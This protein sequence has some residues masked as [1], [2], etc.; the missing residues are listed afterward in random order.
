MK[1]NF[2]VLAQR[3]NTNSVKYDEYNSCLP[4]WVADMDFL[5]APKIKEALQKDLDVGAIGYTTIPDAFY[6]AFVNLYHRRYNTDFTKEDLVYVSGVVAAIDAIMKE[7]CE[8]GDNIAMLSPIYHTFFHCIENNGMHPLVSEMIPGGNKYSINWG[9]L[10]EKL[11]DPKTKLFILCNPHNPMGRI[12]DEDEL[13]KIEELC[14]INNVL[15]VS[16]EIHGLLSNPGCKYIPFSNAAKYDN[17]IVCLATSKA[18]NLAGLHSAVIV[19]KNK[20]LRERMQKVFYRD[21]IGEP[22]Y[23]AVNANIAALNDSEDW[24]DEVN[25]YVYL[26]KIYFETYLEKHIPEIRVMRSDATYMVWVDCRNIT[27]DSKKFTQEL[28]EK[29]GLLVCPGIQ[30]GPGGEGFFRINL[31]TSLANVQLATKKLEEFIK[32]NSQN[33]E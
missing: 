3:K 6:E 12:F 20:E 22:N 28:N 16:D 15:I 4:M 27:S 24:L 5:M 17:Y 9:D 1:Y 2:D 33:C 11:A 19:C 29:T 10:Q 23:F 14:F 26:N 8:K 7:V 30:F 21:D 31:A 32:N 13:R 25:H 18:F